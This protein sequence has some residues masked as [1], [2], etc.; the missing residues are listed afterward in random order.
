MVPVITHYSDQNKY[1]H[2]LIIPLIR[3]ESSQLKRRKQVSSAPFFLLDIIHGV[4]GNLLPSLADRLG[5]P[6]LNVAP[7][8]STPPE[9]RQVYRPSAGPRRRETTSKEE[10][11]CEWVLELQ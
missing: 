6:F 2:S 11:A 9:I 3:T 1:L 8:H 5:A 4:L 7:H 10:K